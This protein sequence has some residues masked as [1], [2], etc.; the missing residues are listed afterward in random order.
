MRSLVLWCPGW[1]VGDNFEPVAAA[2]DEVCAGVEVLR[3]GL[4]ACP[5]R[6]AARFHGGE[7][8]AAERMAEAVEAL[9]HEC[10][11]GVAG[12]LFAG[13]LA[14][15]AGVVVPPGGDADFLAGTDI[16]AIGRPG[17]VGTLRRLGIYTLG[18]FAALPAADVLDRFGFDAAHAHRLAAGEPPR[19]TVP[20]ETP[21][22]LTVTADCDPPVDRVDAAAFTGRALAERLQRALSARGLAC[23]RLIVQAVTGAGETLTRT[24]RH[25]GVLTGQAIAERIRWQLDGWLTGGSVGDGG[26]RPTAGITAV[27]LVPDDVIPY[28]G[29]QGGLWGEAGEGRDRAHRALTRVQGLLGPD[30]VVTARPAGGRG[31]AERTRRVTWDTADAL[32]DTSAEP[33]PGGLPAPSPTVLPHEPVSLR[34]LDARGE[35]V[36]VTGRC[37]LT[38][39]PASFRA[40]GEPRAVA[41]TSWA[42]PWPVAERWWRADARRYARLQLGL[43]DGRALLVRIEG[44]RWWVEAGYD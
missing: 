21:P 43:A 17:L 10:R 39:A 14:A 5:A 19:P 36:A 40:M 33:W 18:D 1:L 32:P 28:S 23:T 26:A 15:R 12:G 20:R 31:E 30:A 11:V 29:T 7:E 27:T 38:A 4:L 44:G 25:D 35:P 42:G 8:A 2:V 13:W 37:L 24:W 34:L 22:D 41:V 9:G 3:P 6:G 16:A